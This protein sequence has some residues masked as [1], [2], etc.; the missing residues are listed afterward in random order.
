[1]QTKSSKLVF[2]DCDAIK[3]FLADSLFVSEKA[4]SSQYFWILP[5]P[6]LHS[7]LAIIPL[8]YIYWTWSRGKIWR[9]L[10]MWPWPKPSCAAVSAVK[11]GKYLWILRKFKPNFVLTCRDKLHITDEYCNQSRLR[12][13]LITYVLSTHAFHEIA[14]S[15]LIQH[16]P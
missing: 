10:T 2:H 4:S 7:Q 16:V 1:M 11:W 5:K 12:V 14:S 15:F 9:M 6:C 3:I 8:H 13:N